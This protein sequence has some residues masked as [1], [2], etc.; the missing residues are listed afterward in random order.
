MH[1]AAEQNQA[2]MVWPGGNLVGAV[3]ASDSGVTG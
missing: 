2:D 1:P 3:P